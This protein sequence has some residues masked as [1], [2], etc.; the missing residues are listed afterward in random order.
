MTNSEKIIYSIDCTT[1]DG[2]INYFN[3]GRDNIS[4]L[5]YPTHYVRNIDNYLYTRI[6]N[7]T[8]STDTSLIYPIHEC[9]L[10][11]TYK[12]N[13]SSG[14]TNIVTL[15]AIVVNGKVIDSSIKLACTPLNYSES[16]GGEI[17]TIRVALKNILNENDVTVKNLGLWLYTEDIIDIVIRDLS[18]L[19]YNEIPNNIYHQFLECSYET[20]YLNNEDVV[21]EVNMY[22]YIESA[23]TEL[24]TSKHS[25]EAL[26]KMVD[27]LTAYNA[28]SEN[29]YKFVS[30]IYTDTYRITDINTDEIIR[31]ALLQY[32]E[33]NESPVTITDNYIK[34][35][36]TGN[37]LI[38]LKVNMDIHEGDPTNMKMSLFL[39]DDRIEET[40]T[41]LYL[42][43]NNK[44]HPLGFL[45]GQFKIQLSP[46]DKLY[47]KARWTNKD[48]VEVENHCSLQITKLNTIKN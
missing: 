29:D 40:T 2:E 1:S 20:E 35:N 44:V 42:D 9:F 13:N 19:S 41:T 18:S 47:L 21:Y 3:T 46:S 38:A 32:V 31:P 6:L 23:G 8:L 36:E 33:F 12:N 43:P 37:Y 34:V 22:N 7:I 17:H 27:S 5:N 45:S 26:I 15:D 25:Q 24:A 48:N 28:T 4:G 14:L 30:V 10:L 39:N 11:T 16:I